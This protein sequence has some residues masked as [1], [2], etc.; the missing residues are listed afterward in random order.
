MAT[1][2]P[3]CTLS[4]SFT[5]QTTLNLLSLCIGCSAFI[6]L[7]SFLS[8]PLSS[9]AIE[10][11]KNRPMA[12][13]DQRIDAEFKKQQ[14]KWQTHTRKGKERKKFV[15]PVTCNKLGSIWWSPGCGLC[16]AG[17]SVCYEFL[18]GIACFFA[19]LFGNANSRCRSRCLNFQKRDRHRS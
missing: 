18:P 12:H 11:A 13:S 17:G 7:F 2:P 19:F 3:P 16:A 15:L 6:S 1:S 14:K 10:A 5:M 4:D 8:V 9:Y